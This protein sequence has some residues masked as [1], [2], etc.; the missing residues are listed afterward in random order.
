[1]FLLVKTLLHCTIFSATSTRLTMLENVALQVAE[2]GCYTTA[3]SQQLVVF[4]AGFL[5][6]SPRNE[7]R[8]L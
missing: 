2:V 6:I 8:E 4:L 1:M 3:R 7:K 5:Y